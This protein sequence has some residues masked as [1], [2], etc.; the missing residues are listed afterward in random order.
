MVSA[1]RKLIAAILLVAAIGL[2]A[3]AYSFYSEYTIA[4]NLARYARNNPDEMALRYAIE[5]REK[6]IAG[7]LASADRNRN[8]ALLSAVGSLLLG[9]GGVV[10]FLSARRGDK[11]VAAVADANKPPPDLAALNRWASQAL[12]R[13]VTVKYTPLHNILFALIAV[14]FIGISLLMIIFYGFSGTGA[15]MLP[16]NGALLLTLY[17]IWRRARRRAA[18]AF[19]VSGV[20]RGDNRRL[21]WNDLKSVDYLMVIKQGGRREILWRIELVFNGEEAWV[22]PSRVTNLGEIQNL[23]SSIPTFHQKRLA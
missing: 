4:T 20:T 11:S 6:F 13:P 16:L 21:S 19:D 18:S 10:T 7:E 5:D 14:F 3:F 1:M 9:A 8:L 22:L 2:A 23:L 17:Y 12:A 15:L